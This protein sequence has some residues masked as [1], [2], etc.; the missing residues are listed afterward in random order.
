[1]EV[2]GEDAMVLAGRMLDIRI[3]LHV[4]PESMWTNEILEL[5]ARAVRPPPP[6]ALRKGVLRLRS[7]IDCPE[8][9]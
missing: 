3:E 5:G 9:S 8:T 2:E 6:E 7:G 1:M 4:S